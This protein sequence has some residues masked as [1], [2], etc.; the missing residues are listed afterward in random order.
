MKTKICYTVNPNEILVEASKFLVSLHGLIERVEE[1]SH[2][3]IME[4]NKAAAP[5]E[6][7]ENIIASVAIKLDAMRKKLV[8]IDEKLEDSYDIL[9]GYVNFLKETQEKQKNE[10]GVK[11]EQEEG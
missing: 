6:N 3:N 10:K 2:L 4:V 11:N 8:K 1:S 5:G 7:T 9:L